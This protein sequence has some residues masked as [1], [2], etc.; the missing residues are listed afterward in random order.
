MTKDFYFIAALKNQSP[1]LLLKV[2]QIKLASCRLKKVIMAKF[3]GG[4]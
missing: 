3:A 2:S 4:K 1:S